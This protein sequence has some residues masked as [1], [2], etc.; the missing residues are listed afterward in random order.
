M[1][2]VYKKI[3]ELPPASTLTGAELVPVSQGG[4]TRYT[5]LS[6]VANQFQG[7][8]GGGVSSTYVDTADATTLASANSH[9]DTAAAAAQTAAF[10][11]A[12]AGDVTTLN[13]AKAY[14]DSVAAGGGVAQS[15]VDTG[16]T[17]TLASAHSYADT[18]DAT[19]LSSAQAYADSAA[20]AAQSAAQSYA[21]THDTTTLNSAKAYTD[22]QIAGVSGVSTTYVDSGDSNT[23]ATAK[24]YADSVGGSSG[25][26]SVGGTAPELAP[27]FGTWTLNLNGGAAGTVVQDSTSVTFA[28][29]QNVAYAMKAVTLEDST[30]YDYSFTVSGYTGGSVRLLV[31]GNTTAHLGATSNFSANGTY[32]GTVITSAGGTLT[33]QLRIQA[34]GANGT[35]SF[36]V[37]ALSVK[38][39][40]LAGTTRPMNDKATEIEV[41]VVD[42]GADKS[43]VGDSTTAFNSAI[44]SGAKRVHV[45]AGTYKVT[46]LVINKNIELFGDGP[47]NTTINCTTATT[48]GMALQRDSV[49]LGKT[50][51]VLR[52]FKLAYT[53]T[54]QPTTANW[55][56][57]YVQARCRVENV[58]VRDFTNDGI[59]FA[60]SDANEA[61]ATV[62]SIGNAVFFSSWKNVWSKFNGR[63]GCWIRG[64]A[65]ANYFTNCDFSN[66]KRYGFHH[67]SNG[68]STY[69]NVVMAGQCSYNS[70]IGYYFENGT[71]C[72]MWGTYAE[73][74]GSPTNTNTDGYTNTPYDFYFGDNCTKS[75]FQIG[76]LL[77]GDVG[78]ARVPAVN[79]GTM[80]IW[81]GGQKLWGNT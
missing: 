36:T 67:S 57:I 56:G 77:N 13:S 51:I 73:Y 44:S 47:E 41:S 58:Y 6:D 45:P 1:A 20:S 55:S 39:S 60:P 70:N 69:G 19:T 71:N 7:A 35:N 59:Y 22:T 65:N 79:A 37:S 8:A 4:V 3:P 40:G 27:A 2:I 61:T 26:Y 42:Y 28:G 52:N 64:G 5:T 14:A 81:H 43:G 78:K 46:N 10:S 49:L 15:Y 30:T 38:K 29:S 24:A 31:Y 50:T 48:H 74:N 18:H 80:Q 76:T 62:G 17:N 16:D 32:T 53:G 72:T 68:Y 75:W 33:N 9:A 25:T 23:L 21:D 12:D 34:T 11:H 54:G 63:D 66:N